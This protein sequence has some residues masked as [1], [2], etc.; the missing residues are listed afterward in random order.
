MR[1]WH[2]WVIVWTAPYRDVVM[3]PTLPGRFAYLIGPLCR[4]RNAGLTAD[5]R[6]GFLVTPGPRRTRQVVAN[7]LHRKRI[8]KSICARV[9]H[10]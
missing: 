8:T 9:L 7:G 6:S 2:M 5:S 10:C 4:A 1:R 3:Y